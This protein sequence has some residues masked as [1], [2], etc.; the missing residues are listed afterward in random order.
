MDRLDYYDITP[1][2]MDAYLSAHGHHLSKPMLE[3]AVSMM[4]DR[5]GKTVVIPDK[6]QLDNILVSHGVT[7]ERNKSYYDPIYVWCMLRADCFGSS[8]AD[9]LH[10]ARGVKDYLDDPDGYE[11]RAFDEFYIKCV[12]KGIDIPWED[13]I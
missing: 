6:K 5:N 9:D 1:K 12:A 13:V 10:M 11:T 2:G 8:L 4:R 3:W 7:L